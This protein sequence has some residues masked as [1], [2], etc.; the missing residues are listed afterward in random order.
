MKKLIVIILVIVS[1]MTCGSVSAIDT[2][3]D[4]ETLETVIVDCKERMAAASQM[5]DAARALGYAENHFIIQ[6]AKTEWHEANDLYQ[7]TY[8]EY[9][10]HKR[11]QQKEE[12]PVA[13][14]IWYYLK[15]DLGYNDY[16]CAGILGNVMAEV[17]GQTLNIQYWLG[18]KGY[19]GMCQWS[20]KY[21]PNAWGLELNEQL[22]YLA[23]TIKNEIDTFGFVYSKG[24][25]YNKFLEMDNEKDAALA[26]AKCY[27][28]CAKEHYNIRT[29]NA[30]KAY[31]YFVG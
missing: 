18:G 17:G 25:N 19:Y 30:T 11:A 3:S 8:I 14:T 29:K 13:T 5:A 9:S 6:M 12:Y 24:F 26:F 27:E 15:E 22:D 16:V 28:R 2:P 23:S 10:S 7:E 1:L 20:K 21:H 31:E 4:F